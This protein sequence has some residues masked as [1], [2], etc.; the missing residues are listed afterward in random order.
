[1]KNGQKEQNQCIC[2]DFVCPN[3]YKGTSGGEF[4]S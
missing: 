3:A 1:M 4:C 2:I